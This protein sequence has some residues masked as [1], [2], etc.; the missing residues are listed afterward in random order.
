MTG[1]QTCALPISDPD[2]I[3][4]EIQIWLNYKQLYEH[5]LK[6]AQRDQMRA[7]EVAYDGVS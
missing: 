4:Y 6:V 2:E 3:D 5:R 1:V 7:E